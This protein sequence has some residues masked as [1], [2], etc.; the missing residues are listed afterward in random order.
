LPITTTS[1]DQMNR[2]SVLI[3]P[4]QNGWRPSS[5]ELAV[6]MLD[7]IARSCVDSCLPVNEQCF[8]AECG[9]W[10]LE[11]TAV[12]YLEQRRLDVTD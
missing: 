9:L 6:V 4:K 11:R 3:A 7:A 10:N 2:A 5:V 12:D 1:D 8:E